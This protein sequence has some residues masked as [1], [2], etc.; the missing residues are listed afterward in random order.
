[1]VDF[2]AK[3]VDP[4][5]E[6]LKRDYLSYALGRARHGSETEKRGA[7]Q[8]LGRMQ[9]DEATSELVRILEDPEI[10]DA[11]RA[12]AVSGLATRADR[13]VLLT[14]QRLQAVDQSP[15][16][17]AAIEKAIQSVIALI[18]DGLREKNQ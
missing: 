7:V 12:S 15:A 13:D 18:E 17:L 11:L 6:P 3:I 14:L 2:Y 1:M 10:P 4:L 16:V 9:Y 8:L 5:E